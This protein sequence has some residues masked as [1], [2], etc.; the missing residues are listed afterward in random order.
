MIRIRVFLRSMRNSDC[1]VCECC[2]WVIFILVC[3]WVCLWMKDC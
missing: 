3:V 2:F 1:D